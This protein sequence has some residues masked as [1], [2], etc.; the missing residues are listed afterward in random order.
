MRLRRDIV[1]YAGL[2]AILVTGLM[3]LLFAGPR[4]LSTPPVTGE[5]S[6]PAPSEARKIRARLFY[7]DPDGVHLDAVEQEVAY[8]EGTIDQARQI[9]AAALGTPPA[10]YLSAIPP[11]TKL[12]A[13]FLTGKGEAYV[14]LS[15]EAQ[16]NHPGGTTG[17]AL[18]VYALV[19]ALTSNLPA[20]SAVQLLIDGKEIDTLAGHLDL[21]RPLEQNLTYANR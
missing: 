5:S 19:N 14:D 16:K 1:M 18:T 3:L 15:P 13:L 10:P 21:R 11:G 12:Q 7:V 17:E 8:G 4:W 20:I 6:A 9:I 2:A